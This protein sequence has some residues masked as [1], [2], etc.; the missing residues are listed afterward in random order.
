MRPAWGVASITNTV[1]ASWNMNLIPF[2][3][4]TAH[5]L[6]PSSPLLV[7][8]AGWIAIGRSPV[9]RLSIKPLHSIFSVANDNL[10]IYLSIMRCLGKRILVFQWI[11]WFLDT[12]TDCTRLY[13]QIEKTSKL[14][15]CFCHILKQDTPMLWSLLMESTLFSTSI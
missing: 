9:L 11:Q 4:H 15:S 1:I 5:Y 13:R 6:F 2:P 10:G 14:T 3:N 8:W 7:A 12:K